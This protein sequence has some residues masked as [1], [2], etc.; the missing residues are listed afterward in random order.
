M[1]KVKMEKLHAS[2]MAKQALD[3]VSRLINDH[4]SRL[5]GTDACRK[6]AH[7]LSEELKKSCDSVALESFDI[8]PDAFLGW[9]K[10][11]V[12]LYPVAL[13]FSWL[14]VGLL[15]FML[16]GSSLT[17]MVLQFFFYKEVLDRFY[18]QAEGINVY[19]VIE[20]QQK[21]KNT[22]V[23][24]GHHD[25]AKIFTLYLDKPHLYLLRIS[26]GLGSIVALTLLSLI[27][28]FKGAIVSFRLPSMGFGIALVVLTVTLPWIFRLW[29]FAAKEGTPGAGDNLIASAMGVEL[30]HYFKNRQSKLKHTRL[31]FASFDA[32]EAG[33]RGARD[34]FTTH[35]GDEKL[36]GGKVWN[37]NVDCPYY[38]KDLF[39]LTSDINGTVQL[40]QQMATQCVGIAHSMGYEAF[41]Q[42]I[43]FLT[44]GTDAAEAAKKGF[45]AT[46]LMAM[47][48][49][50]KNRAQVYHTPFDTPDAIESEAVERALSIAV[51]FIEQVDQ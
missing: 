20:P 2:F 45:E 26:I 6:T 37:F 24:S 3:L 7:R 10:I 43:A 18:P 49:D 42:P 31:I 27:Q 28:I 47:P 9:I 44:G 13:V 21:V 4:G 51:R 17:I 11:L 1:A 29:N 19:G 23:F 8:H 35:Q 30:A 15:S 32:E 22:V 33:L 41:S 36:L 40:S 12:V 14:S 34:F 16:M 38:A 48:W 46:T 25:S 39:F 5:S 50:N